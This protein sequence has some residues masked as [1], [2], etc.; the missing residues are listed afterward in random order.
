ME[1]FLARKEI[2][3]FMFHHH[4]FLVELQGFQELNWLFKGDLKIVDNLILGD[5]LRILSGLS[6]ISGG[7][8]SG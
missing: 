1:T 7:F 2:K 6:T 8:G 4:M 5:F 3:C